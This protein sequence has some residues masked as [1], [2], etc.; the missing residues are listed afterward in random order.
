MGALSDA[1][2]YALDYAHATGLTLGG[3]ISVSDAQQGGFYGPGGPGPFG[4]AFGPNQY[5]GTVEV[6]TG[7]PVK[8]KRPKV[9]KVHRCFVPRFAYTTLTVTY[10]AS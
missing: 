10:S 3:V 1:H 2:E 6:V 5:C 9:K 7:K 8:G 4:G